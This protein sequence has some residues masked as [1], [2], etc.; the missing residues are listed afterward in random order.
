MTLRHSD[1]L[2]TALDCTFDGMF[3]F[4]MVVVGVHRVEGVDIPTHGDACASVSKP[5]DHLDLDQPLAVDLIIDFLSS[6]LQILQT[7][8]PPEL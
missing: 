7:I 5:E 8:L 6:T 3:R 4:R 1:Q 2:I